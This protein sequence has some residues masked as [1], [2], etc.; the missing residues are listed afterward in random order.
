MGTPTPTSKEMCDM[1]LDARIAVERG[2]YANALA[3]IE[4]LQPLVENM[5]EDRMLLLA[6]ANRGKRALDSRWIQ[7]RIK[8]TA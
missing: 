7:R 4:Q 1:L 3:S 8:Q 6:V 2:D 5:D